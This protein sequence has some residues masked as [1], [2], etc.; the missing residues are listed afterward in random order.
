MG[1][2]ENG[3]WTGSLGQLDRNEVNMTAYVGIMSYAKYQHFDM[4]FPLYNDHLIIIIPIDSEENKAYLI[5]KPF[6]NEVMDAICY[7]VF[8]III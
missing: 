6:S 5:F 7:I 8:L 1:V 4:S 3:S 2:L